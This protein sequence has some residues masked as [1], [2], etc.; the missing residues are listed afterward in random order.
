MI[1]PSCHTP[2]RE[3]A[4]F[5]KGCGQPLKSSEGAQQ[6]QET[7]E[8]PQAV[9]TQAPEAPEQSMPPVSP[10]P[11]A[12]PEQLDPSL[13]PTLILS[14]EKMVA[15]RARRWSAEAQRQSTPDE[16]ANGNSSWSDAPGVL[17]TQTPT[18]EEAQPSVADMPIVLMPPS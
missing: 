6:A 9:A 8:G 17:S 2:N 18:A 13:E 12:A 16:S 15:Y 5:C 7:Q 10:A 1:C 4:K 11:D 3:D 14:P